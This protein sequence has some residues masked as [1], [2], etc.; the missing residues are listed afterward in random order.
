[1]TLFFQSE[2]VNGLKMFLNRSN[3]LIFATQVRLFTMFRFL[4]GPPSEPWYKI[5]FRHSSSE[6]FSPKKTFF[7]KKF[8]IVKIFFIPMLTENKFQQSYLFSHFLQ[9][10]FSRGTNVGYQ[11]SDRTN[12]HPE[13]QH[14]I[15]FS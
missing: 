15:K 7:L 4:I 1:M 9:Y 11:S 5:I 8:E 13:Y 10:R 12:F 2:D 6:H 14:K 3:V